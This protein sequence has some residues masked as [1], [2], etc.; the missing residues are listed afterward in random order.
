MFEPYRE[1]PVVVHQ[2]APHDLYIGRPSKWGN[3]FA[4]G[5]DGTRKEVLELYKEHVIKNMLDDLPELEGLRIAC[6]CKKPSTPN[7]GC[8]GDI[9]VEL[10]KRFV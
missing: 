8:H 1:P 2:S 4:V 9:L 7:K 6:W 10:F 3:P 5:K